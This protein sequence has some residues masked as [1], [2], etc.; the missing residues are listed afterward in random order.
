MKKKKNSW[1]DLI[2]YVL[3]AVFTLAGTLVSLNRYWQYEVFY[4]DF[5]IFDQAIWKVSQFQAPTI[6]HLVIGGKW[7]FADHF[8]PSIF[9]LS[10]FYWL[11]SKSEVLFIVQAVVVGLSGLVLYGIAKQVLKSKLLALSVL[12]CYFLF[13][14][15]QNAVIFDFHELTV[16]TL[17]FML[18]FWAIIN[19][20][21]KLYFL[22]LIITLGFKESLF[23]AGIGIGIATFFLRKEWWRIAI[24]TILLSSCWGLIAIK[25]II[26]AFS[27]NTYFYM[28]TLSGS[29]LNNV[30]ALIDNPLKIKTLFYSFLSFGFLPLFS[31]AFW[32][33]ILQDYALRFLP[34][35][36]ET[37]WGLGLHYN[38]QSA[39]ILSVASVY[40]LRNLMKIKYF[41]R[42]IYILGIILVINAC[43]LYRFVLHG[44]FALAYNPVFY[45]HTQ[46]L[47]FL[48]NLVKKIPANSSVMTQNNLAAHFTHQKVLI[49]RQ[50]YE[51][52]KP[53]Y[54]L[55]D[56]REGQNENDFFATSGNKD[57]ILKNTKKDLNYKLIYNTQ[58]Q[59]IFK[60]VSR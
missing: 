40:G 45:N 54:I 57:D 12:V 26:P 55:I 52:Y 23:T 7:I 21:L 50:D 33:L 41:S 42:H 16:A 47:V 34:A 29:I 51:E 2:P 30:K 5:G 37:R 53:D 60:K 1:I 25:F 22:F 36:F 32:P 14:G 10:P 11:T 15:L 46:D 31:P 59:F 49:L 48:N 35:N 4:Y 28:S 9:L 6:E 20:K 17:P 39:V 56:N 8:E 3:F 38:A 44:P 19:K 43:I 24:F 13:L 58:E 18:T 27:D